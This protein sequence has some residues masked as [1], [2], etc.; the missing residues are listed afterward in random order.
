MP[1]RY[2]VIARNREVSQHFDKEEAIEAAKK[3]P[4]DYR[5][6]VIER[7]YVNE[8]KNATIWTAQHPRS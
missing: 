5:A 8:E 7:T 1:V 3:I 4:L 6:E 2:I